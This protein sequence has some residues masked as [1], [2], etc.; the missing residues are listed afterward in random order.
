MSSTTTTASS[1]TRPMATARPPIDITLIVSPS[2]RI[3][4]NV[5]ITVSGSVTEA[6]SVS[7][8]SRRN[9]QQHDHREHAADQDRVA[10]V[11][12][13]GRDELREIVGLRHPQ[14][15]G[16]RRREI[17]QRRSTPARTSRMLA[18]I[19]C[20]TLM[21]AATVPSPLMSIVRSGAP[22]L[23]RRDVG[24]TD[25]RAALHHDRRRRNVIDRLPESGREHQVLKSGGRIAADRLQ[26]VRRLERV[27]NVADG[28]ARGG[29]PARGRR[30][31]RSRACRSKGLRR[32]RR[33]R[34]RE[35]AGRITKKA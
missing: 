13:R 20:E 21:F 3:T 14:T 6:T 17:L 5:V 4:R 16:Q 2:Q 11:G 32:C 23:H 9:T 22:L 35:S 15:R 24:D 33:R 29:Q 10:H 27:G 18:P 31:P 34:T 19:C 28:Q 26:L 12:D 25:R 30:S 7:R 8:Q 1:M